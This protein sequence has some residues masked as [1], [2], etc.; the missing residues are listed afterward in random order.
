M[1]EKVNEDN[2]WEEHAKKGQAMFEEIEQTNRIACRAEVKIGT[3]KELR[4]DQTRLA[5]ATL[6]KRNRHPITHAISI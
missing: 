2:E 1:I 6:K 3:K 4:V 5:T